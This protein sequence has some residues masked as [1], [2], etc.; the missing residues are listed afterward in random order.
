M[1]KAHHEHRSLDVACEPEAGA[2]GAQRVEWRRLRENARLGTEAMPGGARIWLGADAWE[3]AD[4]LARRE[5][6]DRD[7]LLPAGRTRNGRRSPRS[8]GGSHR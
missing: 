5:A 2:A 7:S 8:T 1:T 3:A 4:D 6:I